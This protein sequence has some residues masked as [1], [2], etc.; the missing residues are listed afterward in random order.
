MQIDVSAALA[1]LYWADDAKFFDDLKLGPVFDPP[2][3]GVA[4]A[5]DSWFARFKELIGPFHWTPQEAL[6]LVAPG[7][8]ARSVICFCLPVVEIAR[9]ANRREKEIPS[10]AWAYVRTFGEEFVTRLRHGLVKRLEEAGYAAV[11]PAVAP[12]CDVQTYPQIGISSRWSERHAAFVAGL[13]TFGLSGGLITRH[14]IAHRLGSVVTNMEI[15]PTPRDYGD[16]A[17]AWCLGMDGTCGA[18]V[19]R[20]PVGSIGKSVAD[21]DKGRCE[22]HYFGVI[23]QRGRAQFGWEGGYGC[24]LCQTAVPCESFNPTERPK[25]A[26]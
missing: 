11:A 5:D 18:C 19:R 8:V 13:G 1:E 15:A 12:Q 24:G 25:G 9:K 20:C 26:A 7:E 22:E 3:V 10:R 17:F 6:A 23:A 2:F 21:R 14:G 16:D 4:L